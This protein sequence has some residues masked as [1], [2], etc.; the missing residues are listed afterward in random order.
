MYPDGSSILTG[1]TLGS[2]S[3]TNAGGYD[4]M[5]MKVDVYG[6]VLWEWQVRI[7]AK[8]CSA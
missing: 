8:D 7:L 6:S 4:I 3:T 2:W 1:D 5:A